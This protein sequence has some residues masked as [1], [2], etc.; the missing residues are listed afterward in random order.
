MPAEFTFDAT[1][2]SPSNCFLVFKISP[3]CRLPASLPSALSFS[4]R[5]IV[6]ARSDGTESARLTFFHDASFLRLSS[7]SREEI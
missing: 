2:I 3:R 7:A 4:H 6:I 5:T 1:A